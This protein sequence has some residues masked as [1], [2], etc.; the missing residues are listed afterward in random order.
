MPTPGGRN[1]I[2]G[3]FFIVV[4]GIAVAVTAVL[5]DAV[6]ALEAKQR[7]TVEFPLDVNAGVLT[8]GAD[9]RIGGSSVGSVADVRIDLQDG[10]PAWLLAEI[11]VDDD[12]S[13][14]ED[15]IIQVEIPILGTGAAV[16]IVDPGVGNVDAPMGGDPLLAEG[17][18]IR[19]RASPG[20]LAQAGLTTDDIALIQESI[21][22]LARFSASANELLETNQPR[23]D[24]ALELLARSMADVEAIIADVRVR[25]PEIG[26]RVDGTLE[27]AE[28]AVA[29]WRTL[30]EQ[31]EARAD[32]IEQIL[33]E[34]RALLADNRPKIDGIIDNVADVAERTN[35][36]V[37]P[38][39]ER[40]SADASQTMADLQALLEQ[41]APGIRRTL[42]NLRLASDQAKLTML[43]VRRSPWRLLQTPST[44]EL[45][46]ELVYDAAR[47][48]A[49]AASDLRSASDSLLALSTDE[50]GP[51]DLGDRQAAIE[52]LQQE[53]VD[54]FGRFRDAEQRLLDEVLEVGG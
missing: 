10:I 45:E 21:E 35:T 1:A 42:A 38:G 9:V 52:R 47:S 32:E 46:S 14:Y 39:I 19:G 24:E 23:I 50:D 31:L 3:G 22:N 17:E 20:L 8:S 5:S 7:Y 2:V 33:A 27:T 36:E 54:T 16:N 37:L 51:V 34:A 43:E 25:V 15:A 41:E 4:V 48:F 6:A 11:E 53:L 12:V 28:G 49:Q 18:R 26:D 29:E 13:I 30:A 44:R 40:A